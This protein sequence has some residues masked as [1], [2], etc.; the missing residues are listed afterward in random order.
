MYTYIREIFYFLKPTK[1]LS[2][3]SSLE[4]KIIQYLHIVTFYFAKCAYYLPL[5]LATV[6]FIRAQLFSIVS[7]TSLLRDQLVKYF[8]TLLLNTLIFF[9]EKH[10][11]LFCTAKASHILSTKY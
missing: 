7:L 6:L 5:L 10:E 1:H 8:T 11:R 2:L 4:G 9:V 3:R